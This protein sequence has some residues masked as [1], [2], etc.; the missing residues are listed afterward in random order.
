MAVKEGVKLDRRVTIAMDALTA[1]QKKALE[2]VLR[3]RDGFLANASRQA[4][5]IRIPGREPLYKMDVG[6]GFKVAYSIVDG[7][8]IVQDVMKKAP[9]RTA[10]VNKKVKP[11]PKAKGPV[12]LARAAGVKKG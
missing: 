10:G 1:S 3:D 5:A 9:S 7:A 8:V 11:V 12:K 2:P 6:Q 4:K